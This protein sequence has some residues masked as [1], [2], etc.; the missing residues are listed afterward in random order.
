MITSRD[1][2]KRSHFLD[3]ESNDTNNHESHMEESL[4][5]N[6]F[7]HE[8]DVK[9][10]NLSYI[11]SMKT[12]KLTTS[13]PFLEMEVLKQKTSETKY[14]KTIRNPVSPMKRRDR[15]SLF[16]VYFDNNDEKMN[17]ELRTSQS[18]QYSSST[19]SC[20]PV[21]LIRKELK[22]SFLKCSITYTKIDE[23]SFHCLSKI[24]EDIIEFTVEIVNL[25]NFVNIKGISIKKVTGPEEAFS[26]IY[27]TLESVLQ[28]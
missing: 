15:P 7:W 3:I 19:T 8:D 4:E 18:N 13:I 27:N 10:N 24:I 12:V 25:P 20:L 16:D 9:Y 28:L 26:E 23:Y 17:D 14:S 21:N 2:K 22:K 6:D 5:N 1:R 11:D